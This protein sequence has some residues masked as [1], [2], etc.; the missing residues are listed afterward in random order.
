MPKAPPIH[1]IDFIR[2]TANHA[3]F[4]AKLTR[5]AITSSV[6]GEYAKHVGD[7]WLS[8]AE[9]HLREAE[10]AARASCTR[11]AF[12]RAYYA[13][14]NAS[15]ALRYLVNG[16]VSLKGDDHG[17][18]AVDLPAD[19]PDAASWSRNITTL[20]EHRLRA[21]YD[22]WRDTASQNALQP[23]EAVQSAKSPYE[24]PW[25]PQDQANLRSMI[26]IMAT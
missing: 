5:L 26:R 4:G 19:L 1:E 23:S 9:E 15:K 7:C 17:K 6:Y 11:T 20:Y 25:N 16:V 8:L 2:L 21:D 10:V 24:N 14:Y 18:A 12:S 22:N 3:E 13:A